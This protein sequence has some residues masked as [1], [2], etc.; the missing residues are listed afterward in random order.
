MLKPPQSIKSFWSDKLI[1]RL[2]YAR[3][4]SVYRLVPKVVTRP[5]NEFEVVE[6]L[7][8]A[9][10]TDIPVTFRTGGT[11]LSGQSVTDG[12]IAEVV[13]DWKDYKILDNGRSIRLQPGVIGARANIYLAS[14]QRRIGPDPASINSAMIGGIVA[15]NSSG[16][17]CGVKNNTYHTLKHIRFILPNG[18]IYDS[19]LP[20]DYQ[21]FIMDESSLCEGLISSKKEIES[22]S[23][24]RNK[25][26]RKYRIK[27]TL[28]YSL[29]AF[30]DF[31]HPL[32]IFS[33]L[34]VGSEGTLAFISSVTLD[35]IPDPPYKSTGLV[36]FPDVTTAVAAIPFFI[37][38]G[39]DAVELMDS[40]SL[41]TAKYHTDA[42]Y[43]YQEVSSETAALLFEYQRGNISDLTILGKNVIDKLTLLKG[44]LAQGIQQSDFE[45]AK[46]W[47]IR[48]GLYPTVGAMR[49]AGTSIIT[50][51]LCYD[52]KDLPKVISRFRSIFKKWHYSDA[53]IFGHAKDGNLHF[54]CSVDLNNS[55]GI[56]SFEGLI[57]DLVDLTTG[58]F[59]GSLKAEHGTGRNMAPFVEAEWGGELYRIMWKIKSLTDPQN[60]MNRGVLL[61]KDKKVHLKNLKPMP[62]IHKSIDLC[63]ECG[64][65]EQICPSRDV[66]LTPRQRITVAR[67]LSLLTSPSEINIVAKDLSYASIDTC[68]VDGLCELACPVNI[69][70]GSFVKHE[71]EQVKSK[72][73]NRLS[74]LSVKNFALTQKIIITLLSITHWFAGIM[75]HGSINLLSKFTRNLLGN[76]TPLWNR[77]LPNSAPKISWRIK[78]TGKSVVYYP[79]CVTRLFSASK[80]VESLANVLGDIAQL[81]G[82]SL[83]I[84][85]GFENS[86]CGMP[87]SSKGYREANIKM[88]ELTI[89]LLYKTSNGGKLP[90]LIDTSPCTHQ[91]INP[92]SQINEKVRKKWEKLSFIDILPFLKMCIDEIDLPPLNKSVILHPTCSTIK[93]DQSHIFT[94]LSNQCAAQ[95]ILPD[96]VGCCGFAGDRGLLFPELTEGATKM[97]AQD[98]RGLKFDISGYSSSRT[99]EVAMMSATHRN[100]ESIGIL[101]RD[102]L[103]QNPVGKRELTHLK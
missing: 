41:R 26:R 31:N 44:A 101:V 39:A 67:E 61:N 76:S 12:I 8:F 57:D 88:L 84:P 22:K 56:I 65:C 43:N 51:D 19:S 23:E 68:A 1:D 47:K 82:Y 48:K 4:A 50:E 87:Y 30:L 21:R 99:C 20:A 92:A 17:V 60:I 29:N 18:H 74:L 3:D 69:N 49:K 5:G 10:R 37:E 6:L 52:F 27:N 89:T 63:V 53:V 103:N 80:K 73:S 46:I 11:S 91:L 36:M 14:Y 15:N 24:I 79:S 7:E 38:T 90:I 16:M 86:C 45:R 55:E 9:R 85:S 32:D 62:M 77:F 66:T 100:Y 78:G 97:E 96:N 98:I 64:F 40:A 2:A 35:T 28:G 75:G 71:R 102:Y 95:S 93:M 42:P 34:L 70:T 94:A 83:I 33:H 59:Q 54:V 81:S 72:F 58:E 13:R 25:I